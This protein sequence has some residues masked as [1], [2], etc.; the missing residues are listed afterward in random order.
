[1]DSNSTKIIFKFRYKHDLTVVHALNLIDYE[2]LS[3]SYDIDDRVNSVSASGQLFTHVLH[4][5]QLTDTDMSFEILKNKMV[6]RNY[7]TSKS[8]WGN[9][10]MLGCFKNN[11]GVF[12]ILVYLWLF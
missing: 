9:L 8:F 2:S 7:D 6:V 3:V 1:M 11:V 10:L 4:N 5:F 12:R